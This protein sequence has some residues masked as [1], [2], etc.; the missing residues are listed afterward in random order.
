[1]TIKIGVIEAEFYAYHGY[2]AGENKMGH[3]FVVDA[4]VTYHHQA[5]ASDDLSLTV[6]Y[7]TIYAICKEEMQNS[8]KLLETVIFNIGTR[9]KALSKDIQATKVSIRKKGVQLG[10]KVDCTWVEVEM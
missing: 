1:M 3:T 10:G 9:I 2:Y 7:E 5:M 6:N 4:I 8:Q